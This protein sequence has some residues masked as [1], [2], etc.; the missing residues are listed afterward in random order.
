MIYPN[1]G[2]SIF[3]HMFVI[4]AVKLKKRFHIPFSH[5]KNISLRTA[6]W[7]KIM[8]SLGVAL[9]IET[10][11]FMVIGSSIMILSVG[12]SSEKSNYNMAK[13]ALNFMKEEIINAKVIINQ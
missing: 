10:I 2:I 6:F 9:I 11:M 3:A 13:K 12:I 4:G 5:K 1:L 7:R 8:L